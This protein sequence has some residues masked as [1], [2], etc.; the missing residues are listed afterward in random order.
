[1]RGRV[2]AAGDRTGS[3]PAGRMVSIGGPSQPLKHVLRTEEFWRVAPRRNC[4]G[5]AECN[6]AP[7]TYEMEGALSGRAVSVRRPVAWLS[8]HR[9]PP[10]SPSHPCEAP[11]SRPLSRPGVASGVVPVSSGESI[12]TASSRRH[13]S[14]FGQLFILFLPS[15]RY[16]QKA[17]GY[18]H[19]AAVFHDLMH[20]SSTGY[21]T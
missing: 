11:V 7:S 21:L 6:E 4:R 3:R 10:A 2:S 5:P 12:S 8:R 19:L 15:T 20:N 13:A 16:P 14:A 18:P 9:G 1:M 17:S